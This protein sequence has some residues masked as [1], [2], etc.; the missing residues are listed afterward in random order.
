MANSMRGV[1]SIAS[2][3]G[4]DPPQVPH[5]MHISRRDTPAVL[6]LTSPRKS[7]VESA[8]G[9]RE[10]SVTTI[11][12][13]FAGPN[14]TVAAGRRHDETCN[15]RT[16]LPLAILGALDPAARAAWPP[17][18]GPLARPSPGNLAPGSP[19]A[20]DLSAPSRDAGAERAP[21]AADALAT[22]GSGAAPCHSS[23]P[24]RCPCGP[25]SALSLIHISEP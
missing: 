11:Q 17:Q 15:T 10:T 23:W 12:S 14:R 8:A 9:W 6:A 25:T 3:D 5:W 13:S 24:G 4:Q 2:A 19:G 7:R 1:W 21:Q 22:V 16:W 18:R 20:R